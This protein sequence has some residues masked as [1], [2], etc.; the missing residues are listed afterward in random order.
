MG[1]SLE[2]I[3]G[4][5]NPGPRYE[6]TRHNV[7]FWF[8]DEL[9]RARRAV[10]RSDSRTQGEIARIEVDGLILWL[11]KPH[12]WMN[13]SG[14][15]VAYL[16]NYYRLQPEQL[17]IAYDDL[18]LPPGTVRLKKGGGH[19]GHNGL[20][21]T[22][23]ALGSPDFHRLRIGIG[24]PG[25]RDAVTPWVLGKPGRD[26]HEA[27]LDSIDRA[28]EILPLAAAGNWSEAMKQLHTAPASP[29]Q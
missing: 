16:M 14:R 1:S 21:D 7:G 22:V 18:D 19:G 4:L 20:R 23:S 13:H 12:T 15:A 2:A 17:L 29:E 5:G 8:A 11:L 6:A 28:M 24:H 3:V 27:M 9:A 26:D 10:F 25:D